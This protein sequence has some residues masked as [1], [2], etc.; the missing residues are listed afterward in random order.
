M[1]HLVFSTVGEHQE[2]CMIGA[3]FKPKSLKPKVGK[4]FIVANAPGLWSLRPVVIKEVQLRFKYERW[5][6][7][8][9]KKS[10]EK[11]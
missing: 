9:Q 8:D 5:K 1:D 2:G 11:R 6:L 10:R 7:K 3:V 4:A